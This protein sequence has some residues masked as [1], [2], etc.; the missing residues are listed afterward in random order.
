MS[1]KNLEELAREAQREYHKE[2]R[3][4][5]PDKVRAKNERYW[6]RRAE[7]MKAEKEAASSED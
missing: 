6:R 1:E 7:R 2:W 4:K 3:R 5:N